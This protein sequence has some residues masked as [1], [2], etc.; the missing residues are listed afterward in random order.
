M[1]PVCLIVRLYL[2]VM[3]A[4][5]VISFVFLF[6]PGWVPPSGLRPVIEFLHAV[7]DPPVNVLR[8]V[9]PQPFGF[10]IDLAFIAWFLLVQ[11]IAIQIC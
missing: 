3:L 9:I 8:R 6:R 5:V 7:V 11:F 2:Y 4:R 10:P 1:S